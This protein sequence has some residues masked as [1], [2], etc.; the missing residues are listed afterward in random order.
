MVMTERRRPFVFVVAPISPPLTGVAAAT[1]SILDYFRTRTDIRLANISPGTANALVRH[2]TKIWRTFLGCLRLVVH[3]RAPSRVLYMSV[4]GGGGILYNIAVALTGRLLRFKI[5]AHHHSFA[6]IDSKSA[7]MAC[8]TRAVGASGTHIVLCPA[9]A[10][11]LRKVYSTSLR[12]LELSGAALL[13]P[14]PRSEFRTGLDFRLGFLSN[15]IVEK[16]LDTSVELLRTARKEGLPVRLVLVGRVP[17]DRAGSLVEAAK[18][19]FGTAFEYRGPIPENEKKNFFHD[20]D[21]FVFPTRY[22]NEAQPRAV[23]E[24][25]AHGVPVLTIA[26][27][28]ITS[29]MGEGAGICVERHKNFVAETMPIVRSWCSNRVLLRNAGARAAERGVQLHI[30]GLQQLAR[31]VDHFEQDAS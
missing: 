20:I 5:F 8:F 14:Q 22:V 15:L 3:A 24:A 4:D 28:C 11:G 16:G 19:E 10:A 27:S 31:L 6:Y 23:L 25:L 29:D 30:S 13:L 2:V 12:T 7:L 9:M 1:E 26:R 17:D 21:V 18:R